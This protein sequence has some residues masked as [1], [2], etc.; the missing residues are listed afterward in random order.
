MTAPLATALVAL[1]LLAWPPPAGGLGGPLPASAD[2]CAASRAALDR[3]GVV[4]VEGQ[5]TD[6]SGV[7]LT[8]CGVV[9]ASPVEVWPV[10]RDCEEYQHFLP[11]VTHSALEYR[12]ADVALCESLIDLP[13]PLGELRAVERVVETPLD[14]G[15][16]ERRWTLE[17]GNYRRLN[18]SWTLLPWEGRTLA[19][20]RL[21]MDPNTVVPD[22]LLRRA[23]SA[24]A[25]KVF[26]AIRDRVR[27]CASAR[28]DGHCRGT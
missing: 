2:P 1:A 27:W 11:G 24:T 9:D 18:G 17:R 19:I 14:G 3:G 16:F 7:A 15:G 23:Q 10:I 12:G 20:Y 4:Y 5:P 8:A 25:P 21:D 6:G 26:A 22:F 28:A 13:F